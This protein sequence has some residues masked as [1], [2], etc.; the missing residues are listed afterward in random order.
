MK[1]RPVELAI[2]AIT[3]YF[4]EFTKKHYEK[5]QRGLDIDDDQLKE[6]MQLIIRLN[7]NLAEWLESL[8]KRKLMWYLIS[9]S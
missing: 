8:A 2:K 6:M 3:K 5:I 9:L 7:P 4:D 1:V